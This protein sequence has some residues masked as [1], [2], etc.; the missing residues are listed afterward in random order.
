MSAV[1][2]K[3]IPK[4]EMLKH[5]TSLEQ[6]IIPKGAFY[7]GWNI[8]DIKQALQEY[9]TTED[10][11]LWA[12]KYNVKCSIISSGKLRPAVRVNLNRKCCCCGGEYYV[13]TMTGRSQ[14]RSYQNYDREVRCSSNYI[15]CIDPYCRA[16]IDVHSECHKFSC[17]CRICNAQ[18]YSAIYHHSVCAS[19]QGKGLLYI[20]S[21]IRNQLKSNI[22]LAPIEDE[23]AKHQL[24]LIVFNLLTM[25]FKKVSLL[26]YTSNYGLDAS[27]RQKDSGRHIS[28]RDIQDVLKHDFSK[29][30]DLCGSIGFGLMCVKGRLLEFLP[31]DVDLVNAVGQYCL[32]IISASLNDQGNK[33]SSRGLINI[34]KAV[35]SN[36]QWD[37]VLAR[38]FHD[39]CAFEVNHTEANSLNSASI[40]TKSTDEVKSQSL[41]KIIEQVNNK[42]LSD[43]E[44]REF[45]LHH[46]LTN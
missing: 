36:F 11:E 18:S 15:T 19:K 16:E 1:E 6:I 7:K 30:D 17:T 41:D 45:V 8:N 2:Y 20:P 10:F 21:K 29:A 38:K 4:I 46:G 40:D 26:R 42:E 12:K 22:A 3:E 23:K 35:Q 44:F 5:V 24:A 43:K 31:D 39:A 34:I 32:E 37:K 25:F 28:C 33:I 27:Y 14:Y 9:L 13:R